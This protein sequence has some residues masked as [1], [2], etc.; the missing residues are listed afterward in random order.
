MGKCYK[1]GQKSIVNSIPLFSST[2]DTQAAGPS[3]GTLAPTRLCPSRNPAPSS[4][5]PPLPKAFTMTSRT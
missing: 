4:L 2:K 3:L 1:S 5:P